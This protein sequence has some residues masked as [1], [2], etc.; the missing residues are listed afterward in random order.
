MVLF[1]K[2]LRSKKRRPFRKP[3]LSRIY[4]MVKAQRPETK[5]W[6]NDV[7]STATA[8]AGTLTH[9]TAIDQGSSV[10][11]RVGNWISLRGV[12]LNY[13]LTPAAASSNNLTRFILF[14]WM[15][16][17]N[18]TPA[19]NSILINNSGG[20]NAY[21]NS[22]YN[23][24]YKDKFRILYDRVHATA[25]AGV[26]A[27]SLVTGRI[28]V[29]PKRM[30]RIKYVDDQGSHYEKGAIYLLVVGSVT[31]AA[32]VYDISYKISYQDS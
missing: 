1:K 30:R 8:V 26:V 20:A 5:Y 27:N 9:L 31:G 16:D 6:D 18:S 7:V 22:P 19:L 12:Y 29:G 10:G 17:Y 32:P 11:Q 15:D 24:V 21:P 23:H 25:P 14:Q 13:F 4:R 2:K 28:R 3:T